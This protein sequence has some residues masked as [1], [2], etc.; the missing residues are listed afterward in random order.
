MYGLIVG[1]Y[2]LI[3]PYFDFSF[4][5]SSLSEGMGINPNNYMIVVIYIS[6]FNSFLEEFFYRGFGLIIL[7]KYFKPTL[8]YVISPLLFAFYHAGMMI[9]MF[10]PL[11]FI[12]LFIALFLAGL[13]FNLLVSHYQSIYPSWIVHMAADLG[14]MSVG[15]ILFGIL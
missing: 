12:L 7:R 5:S 8:S 13:L 4:V 9:G 14:M 15:G 2:F 11:L 10:E 1:G 6:F 3:Q